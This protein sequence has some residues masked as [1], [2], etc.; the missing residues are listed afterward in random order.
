[1]HLLP[2]LLKFFNKKPDLISRPAILNRWILTPSIQNHMTSN[3]RVC[4]G[5]ENS[6]M[7]KKFK[8]NKKGYSLRLRLKISA[9]LRL[10]ILG[11]MYYFQ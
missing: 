8:H 10:I 3:F 2:V 1:V 11:W 6:Y 5:I 4:L 7:F 9:K